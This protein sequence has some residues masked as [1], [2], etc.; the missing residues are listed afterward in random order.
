MYNDGAPPIVYVNSVD[1]RW[2]RVHR[3]MPHRVPNLPMAAARRMAAIALAGV[4]AGCRSPSRHLREADEAAA[5]LADLH[6]A[7]LLTNAVPFRLDRPSNRFRERLIATQNLPTF[8]RDAMERPSAPPPAPAAPM[9]FRDC[10]RAAMENSREYQDAREQVFLAAL[11]LDL[12]SDAFRTSFA[13]LLAGSFADDRSG[14]AARRGAGGSVE[15][16]ASQQVATGARLGAKLAFDLARLLTGDR[17][18]SYGVLADLSLSIPLLRGAGREIVREPVTRAERNLVY[19]ILRLEQFKRSLAVDVA[20]SYF[21]V[22]EQMV[23]VKHQEENLAGIAMVTRRAEELGKAGR[24][25]EVQVNLS[26]QTELTARDRLTVARESMLARMDQFKT[27]LG[28]PVDAEIVFDQRDLDELDAPLP[29]EPAAD[30]AAAV[31]EALERRYDV[32]IA[33]DKVDDAR[34]AARVAEDALRA[35]LDLTFSASAGGRRAP[36]AGGEDDAKLEPSRG[37]YR[38]GF[39]FDLPWERTQQRNAYRKSL[40]ELEA[41]RRAAEAAE[42]QAKS[43]VRAVIRT[44]RQT[45]QVC[46]IQE[47]AVALARRRVESTQLMLEAGRAQMRDLVE[48]RDALL[49]AQNDLVSARV[50]RRVAELD[51]RRAMETLRVT[52]D[53]IMEDPNA[54][55]R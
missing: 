4:A 21:G 10:L 45:A 8:V 5:R 43:D 50:S 16:S 20:R 24:L 1:R 51:Y 47:Q 7:R 3:M 35:G 23:R 55:P 54:A 40:I 9:N 33:W 29:S 14:E 36:T 48:A 32:R 44:L 41:S 11:D 15:S 49:Q 19:A 30:E 2:P 53:G 52:E 28:L 25:P 31:R 27:R 39:T 46:A 13:G 22:L 18:S 6:R 17:G 38:A 34:R 12:E 37:Q 26:R 42:D